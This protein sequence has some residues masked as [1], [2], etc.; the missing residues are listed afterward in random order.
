MGIRSNEA[1]QPALDEGRGTIRERDNM[2]ISDLASQ[3]AAFVEGKAHV[4]TRAIGLLDAGDFERARAEIADL[5]SYVD[6]DDWLDA[7]EGVQ[8]GLAMAGVDAATVRV[9]VASLQEWSALTERPCDERALDAFAGLAATMRNS[10]EPEVFAVIREI[11]F[12]RFF[13]EVEA[14]GGQTEI[15]AWLRRREATRASAVAKGRRVEQL[16]IRMD[17]F[18]EWCACVGQTA[19]EAA[20]DHYAR[21]LLEYLTSNPTD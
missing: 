12:P 19:S 4:Q 3:D 21:L 13:R 9:D 14:F 17:A 8:M 2:N 16:P 7:R 18:L 11:D 20:L 1:H 6:Y 10:S 15:H 5:A